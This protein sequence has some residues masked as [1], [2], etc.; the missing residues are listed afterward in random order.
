MYQPKGR[1][2]PARAGPRRHGEDRSW[3]GR[4]LVNRPSESSATS[5]LC[6]S[7][8]SIP[9]PDSTVPGSWA[10]T[11]RS[12]QLDRGRQVRCGGCR[13]RWPGNGR[14]VGGPMGGGQGRHHREV[15]DAEPFG[16]RAHL[17]GTRSGSADQL[18]REDIARWYEQLANG[19]LLN[20]RSITI[21]RRVLARRSR[22]ALDEGLIG[23]TLPRARAEAS[24]RTP[25]AEGSR[26]LGRVPDPH[27]PDRD[28]GA[29][30]GLARSAV[31]ALRS[32]T[33]RAARA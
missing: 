21:I 18:D 1:Y 7:T 32:A 31:D 5:G 20:K 11:R 24:G 6:G 29:T 15:T 9:R 19:G 12:A 2:R 23:G 25:A 22:T 16:G 30:A 13:R 8:A 27:V 14:L 4:R 26:R 28:R 17:E 3:G 33:K 10:P